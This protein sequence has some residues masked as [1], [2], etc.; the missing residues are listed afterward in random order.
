MRY[1][2][3]LSSSVCI[4]VLDYWMMCIRRTEELKKCANLVDQKRLVTSPMNAI[5]NEIED[6]SNRRFPSVALEADPKINR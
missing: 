3:P 6:S 5:D 2:H 4:Y 1:P